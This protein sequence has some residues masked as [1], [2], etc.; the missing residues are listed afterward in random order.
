L[1]DRIL[2]TSVV[3][4]CMYGCLSCKGNEHRLPIYFSANRL[5]CDKTSILMENS[6]KHPKITFWFVL[7]QGRLVLFLMEMLQL[8][9]Q[10]QDLG[11]YNFI[12]KLHPTC[13]HLEDYVLNNP[14]SIFV[15]KEDQP[16][17]LRFLEALKQ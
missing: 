7:Q 4:C 9:K 6:K 16:C 3:G 2:G 1:P 10:L 8:F 17:L 5:P 13:F 14:P 12:F 15:T 11:N